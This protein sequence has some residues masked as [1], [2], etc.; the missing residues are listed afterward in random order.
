M[1]ERRGAESAEEAEGCWS[2]L[3]GEVIGG[4]IA[5]HRAL[6]GLL[7]SAYAAWLEAELS[8]R[9]ILEL[10]SVE[11]VLPIHKAQLL[12]YLRLSN[13]RLGLLINFNVAVRTQGIPRI[14]NPDLRTASAPSVDSASRVEART[15]HPSPYPT[16]F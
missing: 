7:E 13:L 16:R 1:R 6:A 2:E 15:F 14:V 4:A 12:S 10:K 8:E 11:T 3:T 5:V 9:L